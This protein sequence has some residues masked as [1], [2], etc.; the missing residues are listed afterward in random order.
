M[1]NRLFW[2][3]LLSDAY[4]LGCIYLLLQLFADIEMP[5]F[6]FTQIRN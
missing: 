5:L 1:K 4:A 3:M 6:P 2:V